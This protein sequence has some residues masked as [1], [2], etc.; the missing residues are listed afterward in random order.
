MTVDVIAVIDAAMDDWEHAGDAY[1]Y[2]PPGDEHVA[3]APRDPVEE[4]MARV[5]ALDEWLAHTRILPE[6][7]GWVPTFR[8]GLSDFVAVRDSC[9][10]CLDLIPPAEPTDPRERA[11][12][13]RKTR[14]T[15]PSVRGMDGRPR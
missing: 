15:G 7:R 11:L 10:T 5:L 14:N 4:A 6:P 2:S 1:R 8:D 9:P 12:A 3:M 13:A